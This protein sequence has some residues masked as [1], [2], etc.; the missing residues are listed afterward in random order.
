M[1]YKIIFA[2]SL[3]MIHI[4]FYSCE[5]NNEESRTNQK[6]KQTD[7]ENYF[8]LRYAEALKINKADDNVTILEIIDPNTKN[9]VH[10]YK[11]SNQNGINTPLKS[12][13]PMSA[14]QV[15]M[16]DALGLINTIVAIPSDNYIYS[17]RLI[18]NVNHNQVAL[19]GDFGTSNL[20]SFLKVNPDAIIYSGFDENNPILDKLKKVN[21]Q[22]IANY[23]W[24]ENHPLGRAEWIKYFGLLF[25]KKEKADSIFNQVADNYTS[26]VDSIKMHSTNK[27]TVLVGT[28]YGDQFNVPAGES[29][30]AKILADLNVN[31]K[32]A[33]TE[34]VG[35]QTYSL[36]KIINENKKVDYWL[37][38]AALNKDD[39][40][41]LNDKF[42]LIDAVQNGN[43]YSYF[44]NVNKFWEESALRPDL[45]LLD[46]ATIFH[47]EI[48]EQKSL[49][50]YNK[51][52]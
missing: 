10:E 21:I 45:L 14:T 44:Q 52:D 31:Y 25:D 16:L 39:I 1:K 9:V 22:T 51:V 41:G 6:E 46:L 19:V 34:G 48:F 50:Y 36:E 27:P 7:G 13:I 43:V 28:P 17:K 40:I 2:L 33:E 15:G 5:S 37:N 38:V 24:K 18:N 20:E 12:V 8:D 30:M 35:S 29:Y 11:L 49:H 47:P 42:K 23:E 3:F 4:M 26:I 32:Y